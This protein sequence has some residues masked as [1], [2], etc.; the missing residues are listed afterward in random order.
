M[1][2]FLKEISHVFHLVHTETNACNPKLFLWQ[3]DSRTD[4]LQLYYFC[5]ASFLFNQTLVIWAYI[6]LGIS[7]EYYLNAGLATTQDILLFGYHIKCHLGS[8][9]SGVNYC[10]YF[11][12]PPSA[13]TYL[14]QFILLFNSP[15]SVAKL[16]PGDLITNDLSFL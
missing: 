1:S 8:L 4:Y 2:S 7:L 11:S 10:L 9:E 16:P 13:Q 6:L 3:S 5:Y 12:D 15:I 14:Q